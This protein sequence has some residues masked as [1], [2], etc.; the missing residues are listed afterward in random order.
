MGH[1]QHILLATDL[2]HASEAG[3]RRAGDLA[4]RYQTRFS[5]LCVVEHFPENMALDRIPPEDADPRE[6]F[7]NRRRDLLA[8]VSRSLG[9]ER[10]E[11]YVRVSSRSAKHEILLICRLQR[12][13]QNTHGMLFGRT[14]FSSFAMGHR[15][16]RLLFP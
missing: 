5:A 16:Y 15:R 9:L 10:V 12:G 7:R 2:S 14:A 13:S 8:K 11:Q 4:K 3:A 6:L 1:Y